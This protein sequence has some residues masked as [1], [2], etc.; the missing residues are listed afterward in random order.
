MANLTVNEL[1]AKIYDLRCEILMDKHVQ[2][3][4]RHSGSSYEKWFDDA[5][6]VYAQQHIGDGDPITA[7]IKELFVPEKLLEEKKV[8]GISPDRGVNG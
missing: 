1:E 7:K 2:F 8:G 3:F 4:C 5:R 6:I